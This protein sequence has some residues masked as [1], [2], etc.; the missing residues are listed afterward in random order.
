[1]A[2]GII[3]LVLE[4]NFCDLL[5]L[6]DKLSVLNWGQIPPALFGDQIIIITLDLQVIFCDTMFDRF[7]ICYELWA[8]GQII[9][10][11]IIDPLIINGYFS[12]FD[13]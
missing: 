5:I 12:I 4:V 11:I 7:S 13:K 9:A 10:V 1:M 3:A 6:V 2:A 8:C